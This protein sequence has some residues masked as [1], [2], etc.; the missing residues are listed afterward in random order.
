MRNVSFYFGIHWN[1]YTAVRQ[2]HPCTVDWASIRYWEAQWLTRCSETQRQPTGNHGGYAHFSLF[3]LAAGPPAPFW[4]P[5]L[6]RSASWCVLLR[7][8]GPRWPQ[9]VWWTDST[10]GSGAVLI[11][12][13]HWIINVIKS[14]YTEAWRNMNGFSPWCFT[15]VAMQNVSWSADASRSS[16][17]AHFAS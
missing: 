2:S 8:A 6:S 11:L 15:S 12:P 16:I 1:F 13:A 4:L 9:A 7:L 14:L 10:P 5:P 3:E 17:D